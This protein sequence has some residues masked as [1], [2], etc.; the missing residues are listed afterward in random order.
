MTN[1]FD[2]ELAAF[3]VLKNNEDQRSI[4]PEFAETP[5]GWEREFGPADKNACDDYIKSNWSDLRPKSL[6]ETTSASE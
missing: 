1:P 4:W 6:I 2:D 5:N 3:F